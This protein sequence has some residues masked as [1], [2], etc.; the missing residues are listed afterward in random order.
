ATLIGLGW[1][2]PLS[3]LAIARAYCELA[4]RSL[5]PGVSEILAGMAL[6]ARIGT[7]RA[8]GPGA[9]IKTG[10]APCI[11][12]SGVAGDGYVLAMCPSTSPR[13]TLLVRVH[14]VPGARA[15]VTCGRMRQAL[16]GL[17]PS[18]G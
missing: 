6:S 4:I 11:H 14:G 5:E 17:K 10:T 15:A 1:G 7:G 8:A 9:Y 3:P 13:Y 12:E 16:E 2:W 18:A